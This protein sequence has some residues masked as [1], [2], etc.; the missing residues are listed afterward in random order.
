MAG[1]NLISVGR[2]AFL[3]RP[4]LLGCAERVRRASQ[5]VVFVSNWGRLGRGGRHLV[6]GG[7]ESTGVVAIR[8]DDRRVR[9]GNPILG[10]ADLFPIAPRESSVRFDRINI[11]VDNHNGDYTLPK[12]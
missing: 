10:R 11:L 6:V 7:D 4:A 9:L 1:V 3:C 8:C 5:P 12:Q 2:G